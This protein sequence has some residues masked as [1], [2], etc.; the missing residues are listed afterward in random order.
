ML[1]RKKID[2]CCAYCA[3][4]TALDEETVLCCKKGVRSNDSKCR[5]FTYDP[6]KRIPVKAKAMDFSKYKEY[7]YSL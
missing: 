6:C 1:F 5:K 3:Q 7:D 2:R 4:S